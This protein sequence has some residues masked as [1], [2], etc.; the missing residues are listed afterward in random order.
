MSIK[1]S[2]ISAGESPRRRNTV[3]CIRNDFQKDWLFHAR[4]LSLEPAGFFSYRR[5]FVPLSRIINPKIDTGE[6][7]L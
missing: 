2:G 7:F 6:Q 3:Q 4:R 5:F 1:R